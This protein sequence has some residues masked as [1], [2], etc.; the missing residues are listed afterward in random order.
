MPK[1]PEVIRNNFLGNSLLNPFDPN[2]YIFMLNNNEVSNYKIFLSLGVISG[3]YK[4]MLIKKGSAFR[5]VTF[6]IRHDQ[7]EINNLTNVHLKL[8]D[9]IQAEIRKYDSARK[10]LELAQ[11]NP[12][13]K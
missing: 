11:Q 2:R 10:I 7:D 5:E 6:N 1:I 9:D 12:Y 8:V 4:Y 3:D 13:N